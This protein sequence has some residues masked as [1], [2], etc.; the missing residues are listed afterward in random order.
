[1]KVG[2][3]VLEQTGGLIYLL[4]GG[5]SS[6]RTWAEPR[7]LNKGAPLRGRP[8]FS[9]RRNP[10]GSASCL[11]PP[12]SFLRSQKPLRTQ[13]ALPPAWSL[14]SSVL[15]S[16]EPLR[17]PGGSAS[18]LEP[19]VKFFAEPGASEKSRRLCLLPG[20]SRQVFGSWQSQEP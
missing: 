11:E 8:S 17:N 14:P 16:Q 19:P 7:A 1:M 9:R 3:S 15:R 6:F 4:A 2:L 13:E 18:C 5:A 20:A 10:G 12:V